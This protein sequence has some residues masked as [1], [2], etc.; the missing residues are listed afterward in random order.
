MYC[1]HE[2]TDTRLLLHA[3][4]TSLSQESVV[5]KSPDTDVL[6]MMV[7]H[8]HAITTDL[9]F[10]TGTGNNRRIISIE[11]IYESL[12]PDL[13]AALLGFHAFTGQTK[14]IFPV[15]TLTDTNEK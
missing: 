8:K 1:D 9:Y 14:V 10:D 12:G 2:E 3:C 5:V 13:S 7:G 15:P 4:Q 6:I 11:S